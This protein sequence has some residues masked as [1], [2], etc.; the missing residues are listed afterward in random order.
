MHIDAAD[1]QVWNVRLGK[2]AED[3]VIEGEEPYPPDYTLVVPN[4]VLRA[5][6]DG[7]VGWEE[8]LLSLR[9]RLHRDAVGRGKIAAAR[10][11]D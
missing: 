5:I 10:Q 1:G 11:H 6:L 9:V 3:H 2:L 7:D 4:R 8:A